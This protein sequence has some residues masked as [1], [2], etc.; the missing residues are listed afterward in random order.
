MYTRLELRGLHSFE[1]L[2]VSA[3]FLPG[4]WRTIELKQLAPALSFHIASRNETQLG[5]SGGD[6]IYNATSRE[7]KDV[8]RLVLELEDHRFFHHAGIDLPSIIRACVRNLRAGQVVQGGSTITQ[9]LVRNTLIT[10]DR[11]LVRK[12]VEMLLAMK[13]ERHYTKDEILYLYCNSVYL[14]PGL[15]GFSAASRVI[16]RKPLSTLSREELYGLI[17]LLRRPSATFPILDTA[18]PSSNDGLS[19]PEF[20]NP[21]AQF[22]I[23]RATYGQSEWRASEVHAWDN[24]SGIH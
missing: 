22:L 1:K 2:V 7:L 10:P 17:G 14:G 13:V 8:K 15:R 23:C 21:A 6:L 11:S 18:A 16:Y 24:S 3:K 4:A 19:L 9:Q 5:I 12:A 20:L